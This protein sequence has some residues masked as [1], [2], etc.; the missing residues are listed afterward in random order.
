MSRQHRSARALLAACAVLLAGCS[1]GD[2][3]EVNSWMAQVKAQTKVRVTPIA[4][5]KTFIPFAYSGVAAVD[6][7]NPNKLLGELALA[8]EK[9]DSPFKPDVTR[10]REH[11][12]T[13][14]ID[15]MRMVGSMQKAGVTYGLL[16]ID[17]NVYQVKR[18]QHLGQNFGIVTAVDDAAISIKETVQD[19]AGEWVER[20]SK[21]ELQ[22]S[23]E[24]TK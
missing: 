22:E 21:L 20:M 24:S 14:P 23:K 5:P 1:D 9:A 6:P 12:E 7:F 15:T 3:R 2:I 16:Q 4:E 18:G 17:R 19:A 11:L 8:A 13:F 10:R